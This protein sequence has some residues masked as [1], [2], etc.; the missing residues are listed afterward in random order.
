[1]SRWRVVAAAITAIGRGEGFHLFPHRIPVGSVMTLGRDG[2]ES[3]GGCQPAPCTCGSTT[4][5]TPSSSYC[6]VPA[7]EQHNHV[8]GNESTTTRGR[9]CGRRQISMACSRAD[10]PR[11]QICARCAVPAATAGLS[12]IS[13]SLSAHCWQLSAVS[14]VSFVDL[15]CFRASTRLPRKRGADSLPGGRPCSVRGYRFS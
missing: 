12:P 9:Q 14:F 7:G 8:C 1:M 11:L 10:L 13:L 4:A 2:R 6:V 15:C 5:P 3:C